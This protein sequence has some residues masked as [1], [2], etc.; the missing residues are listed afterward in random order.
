MGRT[1]SAKEVGAPPGRRRRLSRNPG[2]MAG[3]VTARPAR[4]PGP[5]PPSP[6][7][8]VLRSGGDGRRRHP[9]P[10]LR[11]ADPTHALERGR[12]RERAAVADLAATEPTVAPGS[13]SRSAAS[14]IRQLGQER[15]RRLADELVEAARERRARHADLVARASRPST[16]CAGS[17]CSSRSAGPTTGSPCARYQPGAC[18][19]RAREPRAQDGDEQ[20]VEQPVEHRLLAG[21]VLDD[22]VGQQRRRAASPK[23]SPRSDE[24][25]RQRVAA[26]AG[27][28][29]PSSW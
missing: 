14:A 5:P 25:R 16:G 4:R 28:T 2:Y 9:A 27:S 29:S 26:A 21:L 15:H 6:L 12:E 24:Q 7:P 19:L 18:G 13:R 3:F 10:V 22:L 20:Q 8:F 17:W 1:A 23:S 11:R